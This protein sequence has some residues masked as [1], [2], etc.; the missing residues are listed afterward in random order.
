M[1]Q[2]PTKRKETIKSFDFYTLM[3]WFV[4]KMVNE[5]VAEATTSRAAAKK[6]EKTEK[7]INRNFKKLNVLKKQNTLMFRVMMENEHV[8]MILS[9]SIFRHTSIVHPQ[10]NETEHNWKKRRKQ[11]YLLILQTTL[12]LHATQQT[13]DTI[14]VMCMACNVRYNVQKLSTKL[15]SIRPLCVRN[16]P[17]RTH[18]HTHLHIHNVHITYVLLHHFTR[19]WTLKIMHQRTKRRKALGWK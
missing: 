4:H 19:G 18:A 3:R 9:A 15:N 6:K 2:I 11:H 14:C 17:V 12:R 7:K 10:H 13:V 5:T 1:I 8:F 16:I